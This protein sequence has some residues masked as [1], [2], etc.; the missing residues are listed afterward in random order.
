MIKIYG[1]SKDERAIVKKIYKKTL[2]SLRQKDI[3]SVEFCFVLS[4]EIRQHN[5]T[6]RGVDKV[7]DVLSFPALDI[8]ALPVRLENIE[9]C[10]C[11]K[12]RANLG[13]VVVCTEKAVEQAYEFGHSVERETAFLAVHG[14]LHLLG[15]DH[16]EDATDCEMFQI[17]ETV[18]KNCGYNRIKTK[19]H[20]L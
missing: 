18:L 12:R 1:A 3:F 10:E 6:Y 2:K 17:G 7:T 5:K 15:F 8:R 14:L 16:E 9:R 20:A 19:P 11:E 4:D 13:S